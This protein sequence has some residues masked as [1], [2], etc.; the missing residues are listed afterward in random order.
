M[1]GSISWL[2]CRKG[3]SRVRMRAGS[4]VRRAGLV[5]G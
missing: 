1:E 3:F 5:N 4:T 2:D